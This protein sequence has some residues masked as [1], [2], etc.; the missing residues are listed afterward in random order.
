M[1]NV[2]GISM[3]LSG[4]YLSDLM[5]KFRVFLARQVSSNGSDDTTIA[6]FG[7]SWTLR[8]RNAIVTQ[9]KVTP[10]HTK[11]LGNWAREAIIAIRNRL[12]QARDTKTRFG[13][14]SFGKGMW[15]EPR[16]CSRQ[17]SNSTEYSCGR[18]MDAGWLNSKITALSGT[19]A[20][21]ASQIGFCSIGRRAYAFSPMI[22]MSCYT[23]AK[24]NSDSAAEIPIPQA[25]RAGSRSIHRPSIR[26]SVFYGAT[27]RPD[28]RLMEL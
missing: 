13:I 16:M 6:A 19:L 4:E 17:G 25:A 18:A 10:H 27:R 15:R 12:I 5:T 24:R 26:T 20:Y 23:T 2:H 14:T 28:S 11:L 22:V 1:L 21:A 7:I 9:G 8:T 3:M